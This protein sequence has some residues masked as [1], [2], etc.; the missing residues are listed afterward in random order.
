MTRGLLRQNSRFIAVVAQYIYLLLQSQLK[1]EDSISI[2]PA[3]VKVYYKQQFVVVVQ[4][5]DVFSQDLIKSICW[6]V[7]VAHEEDMNTNC[8]SEMLLWYNAGFI[9][10]IYKFSCICNTRLRLYPQYSWQTLDDIGS[11]QQLTINFFSYYIQYLQNCDLLLA[12]IL[13]L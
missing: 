3:L 5:S 2:P 8:L 4:L 10:R 6:N 12:H 13:Y 9:L 7:E 11:L 1:L